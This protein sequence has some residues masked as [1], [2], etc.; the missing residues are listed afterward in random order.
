MILAKSD[1]TTLLSHIN[2]CLRIWEELK[3]S[4]PVLPKITGLDHYWDLLF[5]AIYVHDFGKAQKEFQKVLQGK[6]NL[7]QHQRHEL[8][9]IPFVDKF[10]IDEKAKNLIKRAVLGHHKDFSTLYLD[11][12]KD[13][14]IIDFEKHN[15]WKP[16]GLEHP[17]DFWNNLRSAFLIKDL[18]DIIEAYTRISAR[19]GILIEFKKPVT[20]VEQ[21]HP[22]LEFTSQ[23]EAYIPQTKDY[24]QNM[25]LWGG[26][27]ICDHYGSAGIENIFRLNDT[28]FTFL[29]NLRE[30]LKTKNKDF[31]DHQKKCSSQKQSCLLVA[32]TGSGKTEAAMLWLRNQFY[33]QGRIFYILPFTAS[34][35]AM[36]KRLCSVMDP[37][38]NEFSNFIGLQH[39][40][41][42]FYLASYNQSESQ[43]EIH[44]RNQK[45]KLLREQLARMQ[46]PLKIVTPFQLLKYFFGVKGFEMGLTQLAGA[47]LIFDEIH[48]YDPRTFAQIEVMLD[49]LTKYMGCKAMIM[50]ATLPSFMR[51]ILAKSLNVENPIH[52][53]RSFMQQYIRHRIIVR[54]D[55]V[56]DILNET[57]D[58]L[59]NGNRVIIVCNT[60]RQAQEVYKSMCERSEIRDDHITLLHGRFNAK[61][62][63]LN[64]KNV[65]SDSTRLLVGT[66]AIEVSLDIDFDVMYTEAAPLDALL[67]RFGRV[68]RKGK[69]KYPSPIFLLENGSDSDKFIYPQELVKRTLDIL[70]TIDV[71]NEV[72]VQEL[73]DHVY[74]NWL[75]S[76]NQEY[77]LIK[78][79]FK[80]SLI[81]LQP[82][83]SPK[84]REEDFYDMFSGISVLPACSWNRYKKAV[85]S[86]DFIGSE[87]LL[88][89]IHRG[90]YFK[91]K[92]Q[93]QIET[94]RIVID[95][96]DNRIDSQLVFIAKCRYDPKLGMT[97]E[98]EEIDDDPIF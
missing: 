13:P 46:H 2:D 37:G 92:E 84:E 34:I 91:L 15:K 58:Y 61:D 83:S 41:L 49:Y 1:G 88:V 33:E 97:D 70:H 18:V 60:V 64:E 31:Y 65:F 54:S 9:S 8:Y 23:P 80:D 94:R 59:K 3:K 11:K 28:H 73:L 21:K 44:E 87:Q 51:D 14:A 40:K 17:E 38:A 45:I 55:T 35:N 36:H 82:Y 52:A 39:G 57:V 42:P 67:Q 26:L 86:F 12:Y 30:K 66:Q 74:P 76:Q 77:N 96:E 93:N 20:F 5:A 95:R 32:P 53:D 81:E 98:I 4:L 69:K 75:P 72:K 6:E 62:R 43:V 68:N 24:L 78:T 19:F 71:L 85:E 79:T 63:L 7:W 89:N 47:K 10:N 16:L 56:F 48:A 25:L 90:M 29:D 22:L 50:T 27:K